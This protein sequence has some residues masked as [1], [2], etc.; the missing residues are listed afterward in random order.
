MT[1]QPR[2]AQSSL[3][4]ILSSWQGRLDFIRIH[5]FHSFI[6]QT[7]P[8][9]VNSQDFKDLCNTQSHPN[10]YSGLPTHLCSQVRQ[11][12]Y[13]TASTTSFSMKPCCHS[14]ISFLSWWLCEKTGK[15][16]L[17]CAALEK[18]HST[19]LGSPT[20]MSFPAE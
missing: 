19:G 18:A 2:V 5:G 9:N 15:D 17:S 20:L 1:Q 10:G 13:C 11:G 7:V 12:T 8:T 6:Q 14:I 4:T 16:S 3:I